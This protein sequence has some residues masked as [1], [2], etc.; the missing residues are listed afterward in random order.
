[1]ATIHQDG[2]MRE[3][4][5]L[6]RRMGL[7]ALGVGI[8]LLLPL[9][10]MTMTEEVRWGVFDF[11][12]AAGLLMGTGTAWL[13][14]ERHLRTMKLRLALAGGLAFVLLLVWAELAV[15]IFH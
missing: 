3:R 14:L 6:Y 5:T 2:D 4:Q 9:A 1:M 8:F 13:L 12:A 11:V 10:A 7:L 15:G